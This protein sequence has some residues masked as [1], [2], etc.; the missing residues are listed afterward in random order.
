MLEDEQA[1]TDAGA[2]PRDIASVYGKWREE[3]DAYVIET[4][5][6]Y[7]TYLTGQT[8]GMSD[9]LSL[10]AV[11]AAFD[12]AGVPQEDR[13]DATEYLLLIHSRVMDEVRMREKMAAK[14]G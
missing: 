1:R 7:G 2:E 4:L 13:L 9:A 12:I 14:R 8:N 6:F 11:L 5:A 3:T 10:P